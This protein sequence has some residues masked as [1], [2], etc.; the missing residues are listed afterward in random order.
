[1]KCADTGSSERHHR[2]VLKI[3]IITDYDNM[4]E[5]IPNGDEL[6]SRTEKE[7]EMTTDLLAEAGVE[8]PK[9]LGIRSGILLKTYLILCI[10]LKLYC[11]MILLIVVR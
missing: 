8:E 6:K 4:Y 11:R 9:L 3:R 7:M 1:M 2:K 5:R 10:V